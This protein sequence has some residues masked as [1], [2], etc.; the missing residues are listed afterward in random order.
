MGAE[1]WPDAVRLRGVTES[2]V[3][4]L[5]PNERWN[6]AALG[7]RAPALDEVGGDRVTARTWG[8]TRT[9]RNFDERGEGVVQFVADPRTFV[10][11]A[12]SVREQDDPVIDEAAAWV[13]V[14]VTEHRSG[15]EGDTQW[16][17][18]AL[19]PTESVVRERTV[20][21]FNRGYGAVVEATVAVSRL[22]VPGYD[23]TALLERLR[24][25]ESVVARAGGP[26]EREAYA[27]VREYAD[28]EW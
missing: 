20:P 27:R 14:D 2:V 7:L 10:D 1:G 24:W 28:A 16:V 11:A 23:R 4:T 12:L 25:L 17:D 15:E 9:W 18:W 6:L 21:T 8:R 5:G 3:T 26:A 22:D 13:R 19:A